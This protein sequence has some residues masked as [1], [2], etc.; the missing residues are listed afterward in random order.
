MHFLP[1]QE[2][3]MQSTSQAL[4]FTKGLPFSVIL[5]QK[6][7]GVRVFTD[8][9]AGSYTFKAQFRAS[10]S[11][12]AT[13]FATTTPTITGLGQIKLELTDVQTNLCSGTQLF[14]DVLAYSVAGL[15]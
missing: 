13:L 9:I 12:S 10:K 14:Y 5:E 1:I 3:I 8:F 7:N 6:E 4:A 2:T 15:K 11:P